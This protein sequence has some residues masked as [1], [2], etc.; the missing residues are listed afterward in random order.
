MS[1]VTTPAAIPEL[2]K[3][4]WTIDVQDDGLQLSHGKKKFFLKYTDSLG[5]LVDGEQF[6]LALN[7]IRVRTQ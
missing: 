3:R 7:I 2:K 4:G 5:S 1:N 6:R